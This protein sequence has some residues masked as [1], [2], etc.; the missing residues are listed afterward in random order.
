MVGDLGN[1]FLCCPCRRQEGETGIDFTPAIVRRTQFRPSRPSDPGSKKMLPG[2]PPQFP[3]RH[4]HMRQLKRTELFLA[5]K[6]L[7]NFSPGSAERHPGN[8]A[9]NNNFLYPEKGYI[10]I[11]NP[12]ERSCLETSY[13][14]PSG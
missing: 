9:N 11:V 10:E 8:W 14:T 12:K 13:L 4:G 5:L 7:S 1:V 3:R 2:L 6:A